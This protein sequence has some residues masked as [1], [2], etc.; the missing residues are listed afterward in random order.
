MTKGTII[1]Y[2]TTQSI[3][4][5]GRFYVKNMSSYGWKLESNIA[6]KNSMEVYDRFSGTK[7]S[8]IIPKLPFADT[9]DLSKII[10]DSYILDF[11]NRKAKVRITI[12]PNFVNRRLGSMVNL[13]YFPL[14]E[15]ARG[16]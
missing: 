10:Q 15:P 7:K 1:S 6:T 3:P 16:R 9:E 2:T 5:L 8:I 4:E 13:N 12:F 11:K 14:V